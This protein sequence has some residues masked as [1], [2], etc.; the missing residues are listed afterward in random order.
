M[1]EISGNTDINIKEICFDSRKAGEG[2]VFVAVK[3]TKT[4]GHEYIPEVIGRE[5]KR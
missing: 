4:D 2:S 1:A 5:A 3:G